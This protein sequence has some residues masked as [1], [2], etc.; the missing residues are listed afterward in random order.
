MKR[1]FLATALILLSWS[2]SAGP[3]NIRAYTPSD[4]HSNFSIKTNLLYDAVLVPNIGV[5]ANIYNNFT[6]YA[7]FLYAGWN[8]PSKHFYW[9][10][11]GVQIGI[12]KY[13]GR[14]SRKRL[15]TGHHIGL[16]GQ[17]LAY[18]LQAGYIGQQTPGINMGGGID[19]GYSFPIAPNMNVDVEIG[20]GYLGG[21]YYEYVVW[22]DHYTWRGTVNRAWF[23]PTKASVSLIWLIKPANRARRTR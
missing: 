5:E 22:D 23:G 4:N 17:A 18:D 19:Y 15:F 7:D 16:Y 20:F 11:Y 10:L 2:A 8:M 12:R 13:L 14:A 6:A 9:D 21:K 1:L 3:D